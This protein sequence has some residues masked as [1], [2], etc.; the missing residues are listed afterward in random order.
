MIV[1]FVRDCGIAGI[2]RSC[3]PQ[4][5]ASTY[6][7]SR[8]IFADRIRAKQGNDLNYEN[9]THGRTTVDGAYLISIRAGVELS[10]VATQENLST[11]GTCT[12]GC[13]MAGSSAYN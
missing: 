7:A 2:L 13:Q 6:L 3:H 9:E 10:R 8:K 5:T 12:K 1:A 4:K 11:S